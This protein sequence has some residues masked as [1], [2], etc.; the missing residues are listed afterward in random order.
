MAGT[1][2]TYEAGGV[3]RACRWCK[4]VTGIRISMHDRSA[5]ALL[6]HVRDS[7]PEELTR[8]IQRNEEIEV[9]DIAD[10]ALEVR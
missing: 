9:A 4:Y 6:A 1:D 8:S 3:R 2:F 5:R 10:K 7:H